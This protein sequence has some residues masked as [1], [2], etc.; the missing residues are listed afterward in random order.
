MNLPFLRALIRL[1]AAVLLLLSLPMPA[2]ARTFPQDD[3]FFLP[4]IKS[5]HPALSHV[6]VVIDV[7]HGG[8][9][10]GTSYGTILEKDINLAIAKLTYEQLRKNGYLVLMNRTAD[11]ALSGENLWLRSKSR[12]IK[13]LAQRAHLANEVDPKLVI[14]LHVNAARRSS[15]RGALILHQKNERSKALALSLQSSLNDM[16]GIPNAPIYGRTYYLLK[17]SKSPAVIVEMGFLTNPEDRE[18]LTSKKGQQAIAARI[19]EGVA[20]YL[21]AQKQVKQP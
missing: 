4:E 17:Y 9:D 15:S 7:G 5:D 20:S 1:A 21:K 19:A 11:Y 12:H 10:G 8:I 13:D 2:M 6:D 3:P 14:S 18:L 16:Y